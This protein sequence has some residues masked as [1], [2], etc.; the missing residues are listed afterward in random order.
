[1][2]PLLPGLLAVLLPLAGAVVAWLAP[3]ASR[4]VAMVT[5]AAVLAVVLMAVN[6]VA[7]GGPAAMTLGGWPGTLGIGI[8]VDGV[9]VLFL[10][11]SAAV[12]LAATA[13]GYGYFPAHHPFW[14]LWLLLWAAINAVFITA[15]IFNAYVALELVG[16]TAAILVTLSGERDALAAGL[17]YLLVS[18]V[19]ATLYLAGVALVYTATGTLSLAALASGP[20]PAVAGVLAL[21][22]LALKAALFPLHGWLP[23]AHARAPGPVSAILSALVVKAALYLAW[24]WLEVAPAASG[25]FALLGVGAVVWGSVQALRVGRLK[26]IIA[27]STVAQ[28]GYLAVGVSLAVEGAAG[29]A[30]GVA[31]LALTHALAKGAAFLGAASVV[32]A[33][34]HDRWPSAAAHLRG[35]P[36]LVLAFGLAAASL[37]G[38]PPSGGFVA[39]WYLLQAAAGAGQWLLMALI[40]GGGLLAAAYLYRILHPALDPRPGAEPTRPVPPVLE[41]SALGLALLVTTFGVVVPWAHALV[42]GGAA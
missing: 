20:V 6:G 31:W 36:V 24:R 34:G 12:G 11:A 13:H 5:A 7:I 8:A 40:A 10:L 30:M 25:A 17:R 22:G 16:L 26:A 23:P 1:M 14:A 4:I 3:A 38:L 9:A 39:K 28:M 19:G 29:A 35:R 2:S 15:D 37:A 27:W 42:I 41:W 33:A 21:A 18:L 32:R